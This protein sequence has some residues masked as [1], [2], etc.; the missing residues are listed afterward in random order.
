MS[1]AISPPVAATPDAGASPAAAPNLTGTPF[2]TDWLKA[3]GTFNKASYDRL[4]EDVRWMKET[5]GKY[6]TPEQFIRGTANLV[7]AVGKKGLIPLPDNAPPEVRAERQA[8]L[9]SINGVPKDAKDYGITRPQDL[10]EAAWNQPLA[11]TFTKWAKENSVSPAAA[12]KLIALTSESTKA[13][14]ASQAQYEADFFAG[15]AKHW[16]AQIRQDNI[17]ADRANALADRGAAAL[18]LDLTKSEHQLL[19][20]NSSVRLM[21]MRHALATG[22]DTFV[23]G[24]RPNA[25]ESDPLA[26]AKDAT[27]NQ[28]NPLYAPL[29]DSSHPQHKMAK[30]KLDGLWRLAAMQKR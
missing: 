8:L 20:K 3:D 29:H 14:L 26:Q 24:D 11:D 12:K 6:D 23:N 27:H 2:H 1:D 17:P 19:M 5:L 15:H 30:E 18:G 13:Q 4:P 9:D 28:A 16:D 7:T 22:E 25:G 21:A 10:P